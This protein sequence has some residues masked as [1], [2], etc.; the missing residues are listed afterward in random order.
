MARGFL[1]GFFFGG[2]GDDR[3]VLPEF[4]GGRAARGCAGASPTHRAFAAGKSFRAAGLPAKQCWKIAMRASV[5]SRRRRSAQMI[6]Q[7]N[8]DEKPMIATYRLHTLF[9]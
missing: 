1:S 9:A 7:F 6:R 8:N 2:C 4:E 5:V 3:P